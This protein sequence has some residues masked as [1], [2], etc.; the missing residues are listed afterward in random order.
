MTVGQTY[1]RMS[2][3]WLWSN[4]DSL[5]AR[6]K[7]TRAASFHFVGKTMLIRHG[8][9]SRVHDWCLTFD[10]YGPERL[11]TACSEALPFEVE[12]CRTTDGISVE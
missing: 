7:T 8:A 9:E 2:Q 12:P 4:S 5:R 10:F 6:A 1:R 11:A 3:Q